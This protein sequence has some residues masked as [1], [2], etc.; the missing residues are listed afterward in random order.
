M[1]IAE[2]FSVR[3][4]WGVEVMSIFKCGSEEAKFSVGS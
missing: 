3:N 4:I 2:Q 1:E